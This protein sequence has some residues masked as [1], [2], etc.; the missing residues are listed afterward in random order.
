MSCPERQ[1]SGVGYHMRRTVGLALPMV[2]SRLGIV[3]MSTVDVLVLGQAGTG[4]LADYILG[5]AIQNSLVSM[6]VGLMLGVPV[7]VARETGAGNEGAAGRVW[8]RGISLGA[9]F[10]LVLCIA[11]QFVEPLYLASGQEPELASRAARI[12]GI[13]SVGLPFIAIFFVC[14]SFMEALE[15]PWFGLIAMLIG[16]VVNLALNLVLVF[17]VGP[18][19]ELGARGCALATALTSALLAAG[20]VWYIRFHSTER[21]RFGIIDA[22]ERAKNAPDAAEQLAIGSA[23]G[24]AFLFEAA[25]QAVLT[26]L[27]GWLGMVGLAAHGVLHQFLAIPFMTAYGIAGATQ[28][29]VSNA[30]GRGDGDG[31]RLAGWTGLGLALCVCGTLA[32]AVATN[33]DAALALF[34]GQAEVQAAAAPVLMWVLFATMFDG[35]QVV[36]SNA[37][38]GRGDSWAPTL[39]NL[40]SYWF[41]MVPLAWALAILDGRGLSGIYQ[42]ILLASV[43]A[44]TALCLRFHVQ[45]RST[46]PAGIT[47]PA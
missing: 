34:T 47:L 31:A 39:I 33:R 23:S 46:Q 2:A 19:P 38:R 44:M 29:R 13:L 30:W 26:A 1:N 40:V 25:A 24:G 17:G 14:T 18:V 32:L 3:A 16:T 12:T 45:V 43:T 22:P 37:C 11:L 27:V 6:V 9:A 36:L 5:Q 20:S 35:G 21:R 42:A 8:R 15:R 7:L 4:Q 41:L 28:V 10:G